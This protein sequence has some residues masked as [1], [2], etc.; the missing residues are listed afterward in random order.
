MDE[1][2]NKKGDV[3]RYALEKGCLTA[4]NAVMVGDRE[5]DV[6]GAKENGIYSLGVSYGYGSVFE[7]ENAKPDYI[8]EKVSDIL[9]IV[10]R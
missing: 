3:I 4:E 5:H 7:L 10:L 6:F 1:K 9:E 2:R 8:V